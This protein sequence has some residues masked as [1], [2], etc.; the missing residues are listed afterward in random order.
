MYKKFRFR[1]QLGKQ[2]GKRT[3]TLLKSPSQHLY[4]IHWSLARKLCSKKSLLL[5]CQILGL[6]VNTLAADEKYP[7]LNSNNLTLPIRMELSEKEKKFSQFFATFL[8]SRL[9]FEHFQKKDDPHS[10]C[11]SEITDSENV[12]R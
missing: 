10:F 4:H 9:S 1:G 11:I 5:T 12:V 2:E 7:V 8:K 3:Q 6:L